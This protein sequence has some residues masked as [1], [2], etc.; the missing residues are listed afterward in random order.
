[1][2]ESWT[3]PVDVERV[4]PDQEANAVASE[5]VR[6]LLGRL[7]EEKTGRAA[8]LFVFDAGYDPVKLQRGLE[9]SACQIFVRLRAGRRFY[10]DPDLCDPSAHIGRPR[11]HGPKMK[12]S[13][14]LDLCLE[15]SA[16]HAC[17]DSGYGTVCVRTWHWT[18][19]LNSGATW[20][21]SS[22]TPTATRARRWACMLTQDPQAAR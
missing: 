15:S 21:T 10:G 9:G 3:A 5:Q 11:R 8:P 16:E 4:R 13:D 20:A 22:V 1:M 12:C 18:R 2:R 6:A 14:P 17:E 7:R 19:R